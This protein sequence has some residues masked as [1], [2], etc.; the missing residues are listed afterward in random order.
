[1]VNLLKANR[2]LFRRTSDECFPSIAELRG[3]C[4]NRMESS[5]EYWF[6]PQELIPIARPESLSIRLDSGDESRLNDWSFGQLCRLCGISR[7]T[8]NRLS[9]ETAAQA[10]SE[11]L[12]KSDRP[13]QFLADDDVTRS[14]HGLSYTR[15]WNSELLDLIADYAG[16]FRPPQ[17]A[18]NREGTGLYCGEQDMFVFLVDESSRVEFGEHKFAPGFF[19]WNSEVGRRSLGI[20]TFWYQYVCG[21][22]I[23]WDAIEVNEF[24]RKHTSSVRDGL[25]IIRKYIEGLVAKKDERQNKFGEVIERAFV[26]PIR[27]SRF[28][29][30]QVADEIA[31]FGIS[32][33]LIANAKTTVGD[34]HTVFAWMDALTRLSGSIEFAGARNQLD[35]KIGQLLTLAA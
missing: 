15:L 13:I 2:E 26:A 27:D 33:K 4:H 24:S 34:N 25:D 35:Q 1:M 23:V 20:Q 30:D 11:T 31:S 17:T 10:I 14:I 32:R 8:I 18:F 19:L 22:H 21:N 9:S 16:D 5:R 12:P 29:F 6:K 28:D 7:D 3:H